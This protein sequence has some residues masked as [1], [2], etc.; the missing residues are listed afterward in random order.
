MNNVCT[1]YPADIVG[2]PVKVVQLTA[3]FFEKENNFHMAFVSAIGW[4][5]WESAHEVHL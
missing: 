4:L 3:F 2:L 1:V 5:T